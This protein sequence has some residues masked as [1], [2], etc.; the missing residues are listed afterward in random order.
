MASQEDVNRQH[1]TSMGLDPETLGKPSPRAEQPDRCEVEGLGGR[2]ARPRGHTGHHARGGVAWGDTYVD[3]GG[4]LRE[5]QRASVSDAEFE[6]ERMSPPEPNEGR[7]TSHQAWNPDVRCLKRAGHDGTDWMHENG[8][9]YWSEGAALQEPTKQ[10]EGDQPLPVINDHPSIQSM[11]IADIE[12]RI[13]IGIQRYGTALQPNNG[14]D[15]LLDAYEEAMDLCIYL[16][17]AIV[18]RDLREGS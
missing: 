11:V 2:C 6:R 10:R 5:A 9:H 12:K 14:R 13:E 15:M 1:M 17:G 8:E 3:D 4:R 7:C 18:E 16:K